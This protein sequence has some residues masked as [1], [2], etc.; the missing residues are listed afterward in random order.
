VFKI[1]YSKRAPP[2]YLVD[3]LS[4]LLVDRRRKVVLA[5][6]AQKLAELDGVALV[7]VKLFDEPNLFEPPTKQKA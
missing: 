2:G 7:V 5:E 6:H 1:I 4:E 3:A